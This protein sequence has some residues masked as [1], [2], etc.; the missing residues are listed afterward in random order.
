MVQSRLSNIPPAEP[1]QVTLLEAGEFTGDIDVLTGRPSIVEARAVGD[2]ETLEIAAADVRRL[3]NEVPELSDMLLHAFQARREALEASGFLGLRVIGRSNCAHTLQIREFFYK[4]KVPHTFRD[5]ADEDGK[6]AMAR[7]KSTI[8][9]TPIVETS[10]RV[11][12]KPPLSEVAE[13]V[14]IQ[15]E[16]PDRVFDA[17]IVGAGPAGLAAAVYAGSEGLATLVIDRMGPGGQ[18]GTSSKIENYMGFP[19]GL[20]GTDLANRGYLQAL[21]FGVQ[22]TAPVAVEGMTC[23]SQQLHTLDLS[24][25]QKVRTRAVV[26]ATG[27]SYRKLPVEECDRFVGAGVFYSTTSVEARLCRNSQVIVVGGGNSAGQAAMF[28]ATQSD[29]VKLLLRSNDLRKGM[30]EYL[31]HRIDQSDKIEV[32]MNTEVTELHGDERVESATIRNSEDGSTEQ[33]DCS[34]I[35]VFI[36]AKPYTDWLPPT[37]VLDPKGFV[38]TGPSLRDHKAWTLDAE[39]SALETSCPGVFAAG[40]VRA[41]STKRVAF[42]V[43]DGAMAV[44]CLHQ[45][46]VRRKR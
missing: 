29:R 36:G 43:G 22:F 10:I 4:S 2:C 16:I 26:I 7:L 34:G 45:A 8:A 17:V 21:K 25:G 9:E 30:S 5:V 12:N 38:L 24:T 28:L 14:G 42:A 19:S 35:F 39:P 44:T 27:A 18:A 33:L 40:D 46:R 11:L 32:L 23:D 20:S 31:A 13:F 6:A 37:V 41:D 3:L 15:R 1:K